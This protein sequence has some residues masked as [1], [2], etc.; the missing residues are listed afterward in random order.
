MTAVR[1]NGGIWKN[2]FNRIR[3]VC[4]RHGSIDHAILKCHAGSSI[5]FLPFQQIQGS[6][7]F[8]LPS[9]KIIVQDRIKWAGQG[10]PNIRKFKGYYG[11]IIV[12]SRLAT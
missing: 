11:L 9:T 7:D 8:S 1:W 4:G 5:I 3:G 10:L 12:F 2:L 6:F